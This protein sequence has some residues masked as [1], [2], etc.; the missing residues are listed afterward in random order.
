[1]K[2]KRQG[3]RLAVI[4]LAAVCFAGCGTKE[5]AGESIP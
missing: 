1:M 4:A 2:E 3:F 5:E